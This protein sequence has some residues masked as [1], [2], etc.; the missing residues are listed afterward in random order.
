M[1]DYHA[2]LAGAVA[3]AREAGASLR[4]GL[5]QPGQARGNDRRAEEILRQRLRAVAPWSYRSEEV[6]L[7]RGA[8]PSHLWLIDPVDGTFQYNQGARGSSV[9]VAALRGGVPVL[10]VV[11][12]FAFPDHAGDLIAWAEGCGPIT[13][14]GRAVEDVLV[15]LPLD[16]P[17]VTF[18]DRLVV[19]LSPGA[20]NH[21]HASA[22]RV[23]PARYVTAPSLD[24][25]LA[26]VAVGEGI[27]TLSL[28][29]PVSWDFAAGHA[30]LRAAD[31]IFVN[32]DGL[33]ISYTPEGEST[34]T[35][36][37]AGGRMV[38]AALRKRPWHEPVP[39][40]P[41]EPGPPLV[42]ASR[43]PPA[44]LAG[45]L[46]ADAGVLARAQGCLLGQA[47]GDALG[48]LVEFESPAAILDRY[49]QGCADLADGGT[50]NNLA[51]QPTDDTE[52]AL[53]LARTLVRQGR[54]DQAAVLE[55][56]IDWWNDP[57]TFDR[58]ATIGRALSAAAQGSTADDR[59]ERLRAGANVNSQAN[60]SLMRISPLGIFAA[61]R[62]DEAADL[63]R[64]ESLLTHP[65][66]VCADSCAV[67]AAAVAAAI[68]TDC[69]P[70][71]AHAAAL[72]QAERL[73]VERGVRQAL[74]QARTAPPEDYCTNQ[75]WVLLAL[76]NA[77]YQLLHAA[78]L[79]E[80]VVATVM[81]GGDTDTTA[82][83]AGALLG[84]VHG[85]ATVPPRWVR[86]VRCCRPLPGTP[87]H[88]PRAQEYWPVD[89]LELAELLVVAGTRPDPRP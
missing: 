2:A 25:R 43:C 63:A 60:G 65:N 35:R 1:H 16:A 36:C 49:P 58:G 87:T 80:G 12:A 53:L 48:E 32:E 69:G 19:Y 29:S 57:R 11:F 20:E 71:G 14:N 62:P 38:V 45:R 24:Y 28:N 67:Y 76:Q 74:E 68:A 31:G 39:P 72:R 44:R 42:R 70:E 13:R 7:L 84:A 82:A 4:D 83:I 59:L 37:F 9:A 33:A 15:D 41:G 81:E 50:W 27:A 18:D 78:S 34:C 17:A 5:S 75:G 73:Q 47:A 54:Y 79:E 26:L 46:V 40:P 66:P 77:F 21:P 52:L 51:G 85:R 30:L 23:A 8:E 3:A 56:Y 64:Q 10:G 6:G 89:V 55:A 86:A 22:R 88:H 61:G